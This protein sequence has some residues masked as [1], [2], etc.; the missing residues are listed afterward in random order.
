M[1]TSTKKETQETKVEIPEHDGKLGTGSAFMVL[2]AYKNI[3]PACLQELHFV[4]QDIIIWVYWGRHYMYL[5]AGE[6]WKD[7]DSFG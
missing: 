4:L 2:S 1:Y 5:M 7:D 6:V 3:F